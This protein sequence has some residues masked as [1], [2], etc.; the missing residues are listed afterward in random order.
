MSDYDQLMALPFLRD[1]P[2]PYLFG[3]GRDG[4]VTISTDLG[5]CGYL[6]SFGVKQYNN[7]TLATGGVLQLPAGSG[8]GAL[9]IAVRGKFTWTGGNITGNGATGGNGAS[10]AAGDGGASAGGGATN[11][12]RTTQ[13]AGTGTGNA[14]TALGNIGAGGSGGF[15]TNSTTTGNGSAGVTLSYPGSLGAAPQRNSSVPILLTS[16]SWTTQSQSA[17][18]LVTSNTV[19]PTNASV[20][21]PL[22]A[23]Y[24]IGAAR[25]GSAKAATSQTATGGG[26]GGTGGLVLLLVNEFVYSGS[27]AC[28]LNG[29]N[30]GNGYSSDGVVGALGGEGG[31]GGTF[32]CCYRNLTGSP[33][34]SV[35]GGTKGSNAGTAATGSM[36]NGLAGVAIWLK[37]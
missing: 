12:G 16:L 11:S 17:N 4:D 26:A 27:G 18:S 22:F 30:G 34:V 35:N 23:P 13:G 31:F 20:I 5:D 2:L 24:Q 33:S 25:G 28:S 6:G 21:C 15:S 1:A 36:S 9:I 29:G 8:N 32:M 14:P 37:V 10:G 3:D 7:L 19:A